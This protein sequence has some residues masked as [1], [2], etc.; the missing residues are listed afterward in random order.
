MFKKFNI[1]K[2]SLQATQLHRLHR[3]S[4]RAQWISEFRPL[5]DCVTNVAHN[6]RFCVDNSQTC[7]IESVHLEV[8]VSSTFFLAKVA[9]NRFSV[10]EFNY[11]FT[12]RVWDKHLNQHFT[13]HFSYRVPLLLYFTSR[14][15]LTVTVT[16]TVSRSIPGASN[17]LQWQ[18]THLYFILLCW[19]F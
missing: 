4:N 10:E 3:H 18:I 7:N 8:Q 1:D 9:L 19:F 17:K 6:G 2:R 11:P 15:N 5:Y 14:L 16:M 12:A 13:N